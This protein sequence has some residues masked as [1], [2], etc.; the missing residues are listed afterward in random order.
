MSETLSCLWCSVVG[1]LFCRIS[2]FLL[3]LCHR[4]SVLSLAPAVAVPQ[5]LVMSND[6]VKTDSHWRETSVRGYLVNATYNC[7]P[8][9]VWHEL[10]VELHVARV[11]L[12]Y[13]MS[14]ILPCVGET[15]GGIFHSLILPGYDIQRVLTKENVSIP[16]PGGGLG[17]LHH[18]SRSD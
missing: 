13:A 12:L 2:L 9:S 5:S 3:V 16:Y 1:A 7:C 11:S 15:G 8:G 10:H 17:Q 14:F 18:G 6:M 4:R